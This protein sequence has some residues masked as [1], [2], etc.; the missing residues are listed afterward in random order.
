MDGYYFE[1][2]ICLVYGVLW[3]FWGRAKIEK[4]QRM[5][6]RSWRVVQQQQHRAGAEEGRG[7]TGDRA[8][9]L[10]STTTTRERKHRS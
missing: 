6:V 8:K 10:T 7:V 3:Y 9:L 2:V 4:L 5:P 1:V